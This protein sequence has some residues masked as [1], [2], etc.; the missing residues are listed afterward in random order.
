MYQNNNRKKIFIFT[1][2]S[3]I[4]IIFLAITAIYLKSTEN[5]YGNYIS[6]RNYNKHMPELPKDRRDSLNASLYGIVKYNMSDDRKIAIKD[7]LIREGSV[8]K[9]KKD[10]EISNVNSGSFIVDMA[11]I[12]QSYLLS[13]D[14]SNDNKDNK[15]LGYSAI[16]QCL[17]IDKLAYGD[18][19]CKNNTVDM[20]TDTDPIIEYLPYSTFHHYVTA[21]V[22]DDGKTGL[23]VMIY[24][25]SK[26][27]ID[28]NRQPA[29][30]QYKTETVE[31][32]KSIG[33]NP[34]DYIIDYKV[35]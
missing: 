34:D 23:D 15:Y 28:G 29:I 24:L 11:S 13:Y 32:I 33:L 12:K 2:L 20:E 22:G 27:M 18:F 9:A 17:P 35:N 3:V 7:A 25:V 1:V 8:D 31:W 10:D 26:E 6:I 4:L 19:S 5:I 30:E 14:W 21:N 16:A